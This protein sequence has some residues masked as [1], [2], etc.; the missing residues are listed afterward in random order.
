MNPKSPTQIG[1]TRPCLRFSR[2]LV[3]IPD[4]VSVPC[5]EPNCT[6]KTRP[7]SG[8][9]PAKILPLITMTYAT[10]NPATIPDLY[11][12][13]VWICVFPRKITKPSPRGLVDDRA[14]QWTE[15]DR[16]FPSPRGRGIKGEGQ[17]GTFCLRLLPPPGAIFLRVAARSSLPRGEG[18]GEGQTGN[19]ALPLPRAAE[20][21]SLAAHGAS[22]GQG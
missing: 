21:K 6:V 4:S 10:R 17:T 2:S 18:T 20:T 3:A 8:H 11:R 14:S 22:L 7:K 5:G 1:N 13:P 12:R 19:S 15:Y 16:S 9:F